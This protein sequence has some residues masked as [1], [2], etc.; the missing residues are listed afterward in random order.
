MTNKLVV[1]II[2]NWNL[3]KDLA[4]CLDSLLNSN[5]SPHKII[6]VDNASEDGSQEFI[7]RNYPNIPLITF[8]TNQGYASALNAGINWAI[9]QQAAYVFALNN[10]TLVSPD[11]ISNLVQA[12]DDDKN[13]GIAAPKI[14]FYKNPRRIYSLGDRIFMYL[15]LPISIG[16]NQIDSTKYS[17]V[18]D[19]DYVTGCAMMIRTDCINKVGMFDTSYFMYYEDS[20]FCRRV[21]NI[22]YRIVCQCEATIL[23]KSESSAN[24]DKKN[25]IRIRAKNRMIF[26]KRYPHGPSPFFTYILLWLIAIWRSFQFFFHNQSELIKPYLIGLWEGFINPHKY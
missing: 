4:E 11:A 10:D 15:P 16:K 17:G 23:H 1:T 19:F 6:V 22:G 24:L 14:L 20:D 25:I 13:I 3:K 26:Y 5:Y 8:S 2:P 9:Q 12:L 21:K 7:K 18:I